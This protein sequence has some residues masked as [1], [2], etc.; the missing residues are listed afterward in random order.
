MKD[1]SNLLFASISILLII[2]I[3]ILIFYKTKTDIHLDTYS[4]SKTDKN[5]Y[6][7]NKGVRESSVQRAEPSRGTKAL[8][9]EA[10]VIENFDEAQD[11]ADQQTIIDNNNIINNLLLQ[12]NNAPLVLDSNTDTIN[13]NFINSIGGNINNVVSN[14]SSYSNTNNSVINKNIISLENKLSDLEHTIS[15]MNLKNVKN[16]QYSLIKSLNNGMDMSLINT[17]NTYFTDLKNGSNTAAYLLMMNKGCLSVG[18]NDYN[19]YKCNDKNP[20]Q[21]FKMQHILNETD[22]TNNIDLS[23]PQGKN[24]L[25]SV[26]YP[27]AMIKSVNNDNCLTNNHGKITVQPCYSFV[28]QRWMPLSNDK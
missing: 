9:T 13:K 10:L 22:Y 16:K 5:I 6:N 23:L 20:K 14:I 21:Y 18:A 28:A 12:L 3:V 11:L 2:I 8:A 27:F 4:N 17:P 19:V 15:N 26:D 25:S 7:N 1:K 24:N